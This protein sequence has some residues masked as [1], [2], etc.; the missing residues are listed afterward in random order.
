MNTREHEKVLKRVRSLCL[1]LPEA[2]EVEAW[3]HPTFRADPDQP[4]L[5][6]RC[7]RKRKK[8]V[9]RSRFCGS[10]EPTVPVRELIVQG[11]P[12][13][14]RPDHCDHHSIRWDILDGQGSVRM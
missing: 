1:A 14:M 13:Q 6:R 7:A 5:R 10:N 9:R 3:G 12:G 2:C 11:F 4:G 8:L